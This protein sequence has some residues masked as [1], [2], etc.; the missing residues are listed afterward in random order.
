[1]K[2]IH[3]NIVVIDD[4]LYEVESTLKAIDITFKAFHA[5][6]ANYP[7]ESERIWLFLQKA[8]YNIETQWDKQEGTV[9]A[10]VQEYCKS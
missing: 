9:T 3:Q 1:M 2:E 5:L 7:V 8:I 4:V 10:L 6:H